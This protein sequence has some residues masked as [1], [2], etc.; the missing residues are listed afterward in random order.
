LT[1]SRS[2]SPPTSGEFAK[3]RKSFLP[4]ELLRDVEFPIGRFLLI[5]PNRLSLLQH[6]PQA[7]LDILQVHELV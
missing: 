3:E 2:S 4:G 6:R 5:L 7:F 1:G